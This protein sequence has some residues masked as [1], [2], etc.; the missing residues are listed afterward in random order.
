VGDATSVNK[1]CIR[2]NKEI[3]QQEEKET[4]N[5]FLYKLEVREGR[6][7]PVG[8]GRE[9]E[10]KNLLFLTLVSLQLLEQNSHSLN[11]AQKSPAFER[12]DLTQR[13]NFVMHRTLCGGLVQ[14]MVS[15]GGRRTQSPQVVCP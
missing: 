4:T 8:G 3:L 13:R 2:H 14:S 6:H 5:L 12:W 11:I 1:E 15:I 10:K 7:A 9:R